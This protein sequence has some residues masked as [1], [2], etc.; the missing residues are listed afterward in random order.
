M[1][2]TCR[3]A[4]SAALDLACTLMGRPDV[5]MLDEPT[6]GLDPESRRA[7]W[8][9]IA[10]LR[11]EGAHGAAHDALPRGGREAGRPGRRSCAPAGS[12]ARAP[13]REIV[14]GPALDDRLRRP[15]S[16]DLAAP[17]RGG[18]ASTGAAP[19]SARRRPPAHPDRPCCAG[20]TST[21][22][23]SPTWRSAAPASRRSSCGSPARGTAEPPTTSPTRPSKE[24]SDEHRPSTWP[25]DPARPRPRRDQRRCCCCAT[26]WRIF[27]AFA[28]PLLALALLFSQDPSQ[29]G[30]GI[31]TVATVLVD[32]R[33]C[34]P[35]T[36]TCCPWFVTRRDELVLKRLRTGEVRDAETCS[37]HRAAGRR[38]R[39]C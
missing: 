31:A 16:R 12:C 1:P 33:C 25:P 21:T 32:G 3:A 35:S 17:A 34:S 27:Y 20:P 23:G 30:A 38:D 8:D 26:G 11:D 24:P 28:V 9:L 18:R 2:A 22:C 10:G 39:R 6:T 13:W 5:V 7:V 15:S 36:T 14:G 4:S 19:R 29:P 37:S